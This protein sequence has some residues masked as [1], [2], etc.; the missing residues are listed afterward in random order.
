MEW[1]RYITFGVQHDGCSTSVD[2]V[3]VSLSNM[4]A[5]SAQPSSVTQSTVDELYVSPLSVE[6]KVAL[7]TSVGEEVITEDELRALF[8]ARP[9]PIGIVKT[10]FFRKYFYIII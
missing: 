1:S 3:A 7:A 8:T 2:E 5:S 10:K 6:E 9:H 4:T